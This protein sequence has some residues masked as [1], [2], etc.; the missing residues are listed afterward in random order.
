MDL[1]I[2]EDFHHLR[3]M[4]VFGL[5]YYAIQTLQSLVYQADE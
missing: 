2:I 1:A 4:K 3:T 5:K